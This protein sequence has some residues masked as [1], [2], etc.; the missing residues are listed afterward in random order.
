MVATVGTNGGVI[1]IIGGLVTE[2]HVNLATMP[3]LLTR[4]FNV[5]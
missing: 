4:A 1:A 5:R 2:V 3:F